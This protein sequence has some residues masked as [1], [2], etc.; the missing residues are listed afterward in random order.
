MYQLKGHVI[1]LGIGD[2]ALDCARSALRIGADRV[3]VVF[4]RGFNDMRANE[5]IFDPAAYD[6]I[7]FIPNLAPSK[8]LKD[9]GQAVG[10]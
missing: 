1:V 9:N 7:N 8:V 10:M 4:R 2:T 5:E 3:T 6:K